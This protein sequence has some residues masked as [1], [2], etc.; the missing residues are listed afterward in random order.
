[1]EQN[2]QRPC[3]LLLLVSVGIGS[4]RVCTERS[5]ER[6]AIMQSGGDMRYDVLPRLCI[7]HS[8]DA[9]D[10]FVVL[11]LKLLRLHRLQGTVSVKSDANY[12]QCAARIHIDRAWR[13]S[14][15]VNVDVRSKRRLTSLFT[16]STA[17][18]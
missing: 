5:C 13:C 11:L 8:P 18:Y 15:L 6:H 1:M 2:A 3:P 16:A 4:V 12:I 7:A 10:L 14:L 9:V 17:R